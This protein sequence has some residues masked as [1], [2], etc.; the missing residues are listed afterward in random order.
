[1][2]IFV[3]VRTE[4]KQYQVSV[5]AESEEKAIAMAQHPS[6]PFWYKTPEP[7]K[8]GEAKVVTIEEAE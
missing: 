2:P 6:N 7:T 1:M 8:Y 4:T 3:V 5:E